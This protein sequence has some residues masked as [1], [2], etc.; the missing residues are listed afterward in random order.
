[1]LTDCVTRSLPP[2]RHARRGFGIRT[3]AERSMR[4]IIATV[5]WV[6]RGGPNEAK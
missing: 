1:M 2:Y 3:L 6:R 5:E 4:E